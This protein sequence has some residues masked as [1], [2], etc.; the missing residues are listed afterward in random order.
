MESNKLSGI[1]APLRKTAAGKLYKIVDVNF[2]LNSSNN[3][4]QP[5][6]L[7]LVRLRDIV[8]QVIDEVRLTVSI[9]TNSQLLL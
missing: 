8:L 6:I 1:D 7:E 2:F 9:F 3:T 4:Q 5:T